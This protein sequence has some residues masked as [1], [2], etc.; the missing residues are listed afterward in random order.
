MRHIELHKRETGL[1][2]QTMLLHVY[3][4]ARRNGWAL[5]YDV[6]VNLWERCL[7]YCCVVGEPLEVIC[8]RT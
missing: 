5:V 6:S 8:V 3:R 1:R 2:K 7:E 4:I